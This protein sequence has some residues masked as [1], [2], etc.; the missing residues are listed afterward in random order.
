MHFEFPHIGGSSQGLNKEKESLSVNLN[1]STEPITPRAVPPRPLSIHVNRREYWQ[2]MT[3]ELRLNEFVNDHRHFIS[4]F[5]LF[6]T[7][8]LSSFFI[9]Y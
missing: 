4:I 7:F 3:R 1:R 6:L 9:T 8:F 5:L 2:S